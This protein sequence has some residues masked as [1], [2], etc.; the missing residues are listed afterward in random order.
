MYGSD[1]PTQL[2]FA[3]VQCCHFDG[4]GSASKIE[5]HKDSG[6]RQLMAV[7]LT[8]DEIEQFD[9]ARISK[10]SW[11]QRQLESKLLL[12]AQKVIS[13]EGFGA[14]SLA[15]AMKIQERVSKV[16]SQKA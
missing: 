11:L 3:I 12:A 5:W 9:Q 15:Q 8:P 4:D 2:I 13:G 6:I 1:T 14:D 16:N 7:V 10:V